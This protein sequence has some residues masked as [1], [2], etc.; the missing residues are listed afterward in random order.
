MYTPSANYGVV[1]VV[2]YRAV[3]SKGGKTDEA[4]GI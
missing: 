1:V 2:L 4:K 3:Y